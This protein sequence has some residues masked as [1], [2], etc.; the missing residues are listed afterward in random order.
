MNCATFL[1]FR[2]FWFL[3]FLLPSAG[4]P[5]LT[6]IEF[7]KGDFFYRGQG[8]LPFGG[9]T[10]PELHPRASRDSIRDRQSVNAT[11][12]DAIPTV[13]RGRLKFLKG[14]ARCVN[15]V[16]KRFWFVCWVETRCVN[17]VCR[18]SGFVCGVETLCVNGVSS[19]FLRCCLWG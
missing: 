12:D 19:S 3:Y 5:R 10:V 14:E 7:P 18:V 4:L 13:P 15:R 9:S 16:S 1:V 2:I 8:P 17:Q 11:K 6:T